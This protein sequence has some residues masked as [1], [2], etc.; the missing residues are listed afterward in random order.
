VDPS[1]LVADKHDAPSD[2]IEE[3]PS[4]S[5]MPGHSSY[6]NDHSDHAIQY[7]KQAVFALQVK[8][9][10]ASASLPAPQNSVF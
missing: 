7:A 1:L 3:D 8:M 5:L 4:V 10:S 2:S 6:Q 9:K